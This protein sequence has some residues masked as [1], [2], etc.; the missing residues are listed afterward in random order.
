MM[1]IFAPVTLPDKA[2]TAV[3]QVWQ[4]RP[5]VTDGIPEKHDFQPAYL[6][7]K[8]TLDLLNGHS[9]VAMGENSRIK[10]KIIHGT[11]NVVSWGILPPT[12]VIIASERC[13]S[14]G[15]DPPGRCVGYGS[16]EEPL[17]PQVVANDS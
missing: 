17:R 10:K 9:N 11:L 2:A 4:V 6:N 16:E 14:R 8:G 15:D 5:S 13:T 7:S 3:N 12:G 1:R